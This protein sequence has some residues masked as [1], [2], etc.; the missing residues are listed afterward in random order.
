MWWYFSDIFHFI[1]IFHRTFSVSLSIIFSISSI[2]VSQWL[3]GF[4]N[5]CPRRLKSSRSHVV[6]KTTTGAS[7]SWF[8]L[9]VMRILAVTCDVIHKIRGL[10]LQ[11]LRSSISVR[12]F[13]WFLYCYYTFRTDT[14]SSEGLT[15]APSEFLC[16]HTLICFFYLY[17]T[18]FWTCKVFPGRST[19]FHLCNH[20]DGSSMT[21]A[22]PSDGYKLLVTKYITHELWLVMEC[23]VYS[24]RNNW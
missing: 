13:L 17:M 1:L 2:N 16:G 23:V 15:T 4:P 24:P 20:Y 10:F 22:T 5:S 19:S 21:L 9:T 7:N 6:R 12:M 3:F 8:P 18:C 14:S 11:F